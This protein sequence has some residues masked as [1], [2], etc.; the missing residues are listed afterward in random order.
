MDHSE[1]IAAQYLHSLGFR[2]VQYE[3]DGNVPPDF[4]VGGR[5]AVEVR[6][7]NQNAIGRSGTPEGL[8]EVFV[9]FWQRLQ[10]YLPTMGPSIEGQSWYVG[11]NLRRPLEPWRVLEPRLREVLMQFMHN[12]D[13]RPSIVRVTGHLEIDFVLAGRSYDSFFR[14]G[15]GVDEDS[16][17]FILAEVNKN[18]ELCIAEKTRKIAAYRAK[19]P[20]WWLILLDHIA[21]GFDE[22]DK[23]QFRSMPRVRHD[24]SKI[25]LLSP[26]NAALAFEV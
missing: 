3:P 17:G 23:M 20:E 16:G 21:R 26:H 13:R 15:A 24:W 11:M 5:I 18:L 25:I 12:S 1:H 22:D 4:L 9:P 6:R 2:N 19:Y 14:L 7:L 10:R 8:E